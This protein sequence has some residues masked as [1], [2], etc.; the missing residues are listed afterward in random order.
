MRI[1]WQRCCDGYTDY[2]PCPRCEG[3]GMKEVIVRE[4]GD[5][6]RCDGFGKIAILDMLVPCPERCGSTGYLDI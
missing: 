6:R 2:G 5:C 3:G 4:E 1:E